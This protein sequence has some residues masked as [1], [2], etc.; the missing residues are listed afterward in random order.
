MSFAFLL[1]P[2]LV[3]VGAAVDYT[4][5]LKVQS[6][7][8]DIADA[9]SLDIA[10][11]ATLTEQQMED[12]AQSY[13]DAH[14]DLNPSTFSGVAL[15][16]AGARLVSTDTVQVSLAGAVDTTFMQ[17]IGIDTLDVN[18]SAQAVIGLLSELEIALVL[19]TTKSM[20]GTKIAGLKTA[21]TSLVTKATSKSSAVVR[22]AV[23]PFAQYVNIGISRR[24]EPWVSV[25][26]DYST[27]TPKT[28]KTIS[29]EQDCTSTSYSCTLYNDGVPY[30]GTCT[31]KTCT[32]RA[33]TPYESCT[34][35][36]TNTYKFSGCVGSPARPKNVEDSDP[37]R[38]YPGIMNQTCAKEFT[39]LT[40][41]VTKINAAIKA[42]SATGDTYMP[43]GLAWGF[44]LLS[45]A[46]P[47]T[48][49]AA[50]DET[51]A[52]RYPRKIMVLMT[53]GLN[54]LLLN[55][56]TGKHDKTPATN[57]DGIRGEATQSNLDTL[58]LC[59][60]IKAEHIELFTVAY[61]A[62]ATG[63]ATMLRECATD[64]QHFYLADDSAALLAAFSDIIE[65]VQQVR[66]AH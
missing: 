11:S 2:L 46:Q 29:T 61:G 28:C 32:T 5:A 18:A 38:V 1:L 37:S 52:N 62:D 40:N 53:D 26:D 25:A 57:S 15:D 3:A 19:D 14:V 22:I 66:I 43:A 7:L 10:V 59:T 55:E 17:I 39:P 47:M 24:S 9:A 4:R 65:K 36:T 8:Q 23:I 20:A 64:N 21:A 54:S 13:L 33:V 6:S 63:A 48:E 51:H 27:V 34:G 49:G 60:N 44:N 16:P 31:K 45:H 56:T 30:T 12:R 35:P 50:Y 41:D 42:L 58:A